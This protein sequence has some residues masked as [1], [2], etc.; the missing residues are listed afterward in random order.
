[1]NQAL[2]IFIKNPELGK[3][4]TRLAETVG[5]EKALI[6]YLELLK[7]TQQIACE[8]A[9]NRLLFYSKFID[10]NDNWNNQ[11]FQKQ[12]QNGSSLGERMQAAFEQ[13][14]L[15]YKKAVIIGSDCASLTPSIIEEAFQA[16]DTHDFVVGPAE[17]GGY[18]LL[19]MKQV[20]PTLFQ[21]ME[22]STDQVLPE[23][24]KRIEAKQ[25]SYTL[26]PTLSDIDYWED[27]VKHGWAIAELELVEALK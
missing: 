14:L 4:K 16:L 13:A 1:M 27:W 18:Y 7:H 21:K 15:K 17:D 8:V 11:A 3:V 5:D 20:E 26:L 12:L 22:W 9:A 25:A 19:G 23:T 2:I 10:T 24:L 6:I